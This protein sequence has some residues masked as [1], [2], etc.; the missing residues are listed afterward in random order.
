[1]AHLINVEVQKVLRGDQVDADGKVLL[2][3]LKTLRTS[4]HYFLP[5]PLCPVCGGLPDDTEELARIPLEPSPKV[6]SGSFRS[7]SLDEMKEVIVTD[8]LD[9]RTGV[10][11]SKIYDLVT[12]FAD[13]SVNLPMLAGD[14]RTGG[15][16]HVTKKV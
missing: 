11:N 9:N 1:M 12:P 16:T 4:S 6:S 15:R 5:N 3:D 7:R 2:I 13:A 14:E 10:L 8:Y